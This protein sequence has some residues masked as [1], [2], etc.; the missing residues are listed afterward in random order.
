M[1]KARRVRA[2]KG[3]YL[4]RLETAL[5]SQHFLNL[6]PQALDISSYQ[7]LILHLPWLIKLLGHPLI[8]PFF[9]FSPGSWAP[10][11]SAMGFYDPYKREF[12][13]YYA[14]SVLVNRIILIAIYSSRFLE[15]FRRLLGYNSLRIPWE[16]G[17][18]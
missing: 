13:C 17:V 2:P 4:C 3:P 1:S 14:I 12:H 15:H 7:L 18:S 8:L 11:T 16:K 10:P 5:C 6:R 9:A